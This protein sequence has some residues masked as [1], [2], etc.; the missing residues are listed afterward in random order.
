[1]T[2]GGGATGSGF[3]GGKGTSGFCIVSSSGADSTELKTVGVSG[4]VSP[5]GGATA[6]AG[7]TGCS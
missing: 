2:G 6:E 3:E 4:N 5:S 7:S 1:M